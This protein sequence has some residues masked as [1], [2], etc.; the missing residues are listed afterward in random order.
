MQVSHPPSRAL[1]HLVECHWH[2]RREPPRDQVE[3]ILP[4]AAPELIVHLD[5]PPEVRGASGRWQRQP[6]AILYCA[7]RRCVE[8]RHAAPVNLFAVRF[9][10]WGFAR[11][12][13][14]PMDQLLDRAV[15]LEEAMGAAGTELA[16]AVMS[17]NGETGRIAAAEAGLGAA[18]DTPHPLDRAIAQ[19]ADGLGSARTG[20]S[21]IAERL[22]LS[23]RTVNREWR[24]LVG[25]PPGQY[26]KLMRVHRALEG[27]REGR[28]MAWVASECGYADQAHLARQIK[29]VAGLP[30]SRLR[31]WLG[32]EVYADLYASRGQPPWRTT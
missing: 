29:E 15:P 2:W 23:P 16:E 7:A 30:P 28:P 11:F 25:M 6:R 32:D 12:A 27:I 17:A 18:L 22:A 9:R 21:E 26:A 1:E 31:D 19:L 8:L 24:R 14:R 20:P 13:T 5:E 3:W 10:P 4:D